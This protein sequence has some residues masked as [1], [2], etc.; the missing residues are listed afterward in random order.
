[1]YSKPQLDRFQ[2]NAPPIFRLGNLRSIDLYEVTVDTLQQLM[3]EGLLTSV[4]YVD[5]CLNRI[6]AV[7]MPFRES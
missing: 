5:F 2:D 6:H 3:S 7:R 4:E 1:M